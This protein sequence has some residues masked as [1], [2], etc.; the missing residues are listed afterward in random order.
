MTTNKQAFSFEEIL[1]KMMRFCSYQE[2]SEWEISQK[3]KEY[4]LASAD[5]DQLLN[6]LKE[7]N[8]IDETRFATAFVRG[9]LKVKK[10]GIYKIKQ[11]LIAK[12]V[13][14]SIVSEALKT[15]DYELYL[16]NLKVLFQQKAK[17]LGNS[18]NERAKIY[19]YLLSKGY[20][21]KLVMEILNSNQ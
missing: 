21:S 17:T 7:E 2:R 16:E 13:K 12:G 8:F 19:R 3:V 6:I 9:K 5:T 14:P 11:G 15:I 18:R 1:A 10:W 20:E 4:G